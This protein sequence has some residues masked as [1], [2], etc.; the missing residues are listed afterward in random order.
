MFAPLESI[1]NSIL[2]KIFLILIIFFINQS[3]ED[4]YSKKNEQQNTK[5]SDNITVTTEKGW[6]L[7]WNDEFEANVLDLKKWEWRLVPRT[8]QHYSKCRQQ[9]RQSK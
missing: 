6:E 4:L 5:S 8:D 9:M 1:K 7:V 3:C 2:P